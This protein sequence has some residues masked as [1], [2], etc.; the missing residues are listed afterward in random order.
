[1]SVI[2]EQRWS[3]YD[4]QDHQVWEALKSRQ[5]RLLV[6]RCGL[7]VVQARQDLGFG[8]S[9][10]QFDE[11]SAILHHH[12]GWTLAPVDGLLEIA[13]FFSLLAQKQFPTT[14]W[15]RTPEQMDYL[16]EPDLFHDLYG[17]VPMLMNPVLADFT[18]QFGQAALVHLHDP[19]ILQ[20]LQRLYWFSIEFGL[21]GP[22]ETPLIYGAGI[23]SSKDESLYATQWKHS[24]DADIEEH[25]QEVQQR[26]GRPIV[27]PFVLDE[28]IVQSY[29]I[30]HVQPVYFSIEDLHL[31]H[32]EVS[33]Y[34]QTLISTP[35][36]T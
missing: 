15:I 33:G 7:D 3:D 16:P 22:H 19:H 14:W 11:V 10:P 8:T 24:D 29:D 9:I 5:D 4:P 35:P 23:V 12:T 31:W 1:M 36:M 26:L 2:T 32:E 13:D 21:T 20:A 17:H 30:D 28:V 18:Q 34:L 25:L 27:K 6:G